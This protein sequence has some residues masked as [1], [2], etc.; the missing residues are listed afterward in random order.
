[1]A[2]GNQLALLPTRSIQ[3]FTGILIRCSLS[4]RIGFRP[5]V[6][7]RFHPTSAAA[8]SLISIERDRTQ[9]EG[10]EAR[11]RDW[12]A[13]KGGPTLSWGGLI[14]AQGRL[15]GVPPSGGHPLPG[16]HHTERRAEDPQ[17][18]PLLRGRGAEET[19]ALSPPSLD[20]SV[21]YKETL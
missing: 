7:E 12:S 1:M 9:E 16:A 2:N 4:K 21:R 5:E 6:H 11:G 19:G 13:M 3:I 8:L 14:G 15:P 17:V 20:A 10:G 18:C